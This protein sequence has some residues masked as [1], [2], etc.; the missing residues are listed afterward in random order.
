[1]SDAESNSE[2]NADS[3]D[4]EFVAFKGNDRKLL[5]L[6]EK[7]K[8]DEIGSVIFTEADGMGFNVWASVLSLLKD[9]EKLF[10]I[11]KD[12]S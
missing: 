9:E 6:F 7:T 8:S 12:V 4:V 5:K 3:F 10:E 11:I 1:M 2:S